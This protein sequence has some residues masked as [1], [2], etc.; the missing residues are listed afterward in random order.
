MFATLC[1]IFYNLCIST[2]LHPPRGLLFCTAYLTDTLGRY[3]GG[4]Y[5]EATSRLRWCI[6]RRGEHY[7]P[8]RPHEVYRQRLTAMRAVRCT[9]HENASEAGALLRKVSESFFF[10]RAAL[11]YSVSPGIRGDIW[12]IVSTNVEYRNAPHLGAKM[13]YLLG[14]SPES[15]QHQKRE[16]IPHYTSRYCK[17]T[18]IAT[19]V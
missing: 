5:R 18:S 16:A 14:A 6:D 2:L 7:G 8:A 11:G 4:G 17:H 19:G 13:C 12:T 3:C 9:V 1:S 15:R 10:P